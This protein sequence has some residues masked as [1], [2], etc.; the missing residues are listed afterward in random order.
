M[1]LQRK[2]KLEEKLVKK[3]QKIREWGSPPRSSGLVDLSPKYF[4]CSNSLIDY[5]L[6]VYIYY[7]C[8]W[9]I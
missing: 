4:I 2:H 6:V 8:L 5:W 7:N 1:K 3:G 9:L